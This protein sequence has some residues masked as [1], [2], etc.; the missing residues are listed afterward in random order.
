MDPIYE[1]KSFKKEMFTILPKKNQTR[2]PLIQL[3]AKNLEENGEN[4]FILEIE[5]D[6]SKGFWNI[7][8]VAGYKWRLFSD[9]VGVIALHNVNILSAELCTWSS[10][11]IAEILMKTKVFGPDKPDEI[12][13]RIKRDLQN[14]FTGKLALPYRLHIK[15]F[16]PKTG[17]ASNLSEASKIFIDNGSSERFTKIQ[18]LTNDRVGLLYRIIDALDDLRIVI[19]TANI[20]TDGNKVEDIF[21]VHDQEGKK[22]EDRVRIREIKKALSH[23]VNLIQGR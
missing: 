17:R 6:E 18:I 13:R 16:P 7:T 2:L 5:E 15:L 10:G 3:I 23:Q 9:I 12:W 22:V 21:F 19:K 1:I 11:S 20:F 14:T 4:R 8:C